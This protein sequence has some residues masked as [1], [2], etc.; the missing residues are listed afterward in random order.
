M[1]D[2]RFPYP[3]FRKGQQELAEEVERTAR[4]GELLV[5]NAPTGFGK[6]AA[7]L[8][9]LMKAGA[10]RV[11]YVVRTVNEVDPVIRELKL[12]GARYTF[13]FSARRTCPL[14][15]GDRGQGELTAEEFWEN[16][17][18]ARLRGLCQYYRN[19]QDT[20][21]EAVW[22]YIKS[23]YSMH[24]VRIAR[25]LARA[26][27]VCPFLA[28]TGL[29]EESMFTVAVYP[30]LFRRD[31]FESV[32]EPL[33]Y[34]D[35]V[36]VVDE[37]HSLLNA[38][39]ILEQRLTLKAVRESI[40]DLK[41]HAPEAKE[42]ARVLSDLAAYMQSL[43][44]RDITEIPK[45]AVSW[46]LDSWDIVA[47]AAEEVRRRKF[48]QA[49]ASGAGFASVR[50]PLYRVAKWLEAARS[51]E[52]HI[53]AEPGE[54]PRLLATPVDPAVTAREP[55]EKA[56]AVI[57]MSGTMPPSGF[58]EEVLGVKR[59]RT[60][61]DTEIRHGPMVPPSNIYTVV[62]ADITTRYRERSTAMYRRIAEYIDIIARALPG[63]KLV[64]YPSYDIMRRV[65]ER[66]PADLTLV[67]EG[68][69][70]SLEEARLRIEDEWDV[71]VS[72][73]A[74]GKLVE[75]V[76]FT[77]YEGENLLHI[78]V[79]VGVPYP[80]P[81][82]YTRRHMEALAERI[83]R[84]KARY[85]VYK[86]N[87]SIKVRQALGRAI[88]GPSDRAVYVLLD[89]RYLSR[90]LRELVRIPYRR[91]VWSPDELAGLAG[92]LREHLEQPGY[93]SSSSSVS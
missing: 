45:D 57:L 33:D 78:V 64:V 54:E 52:Y 1:G 46:A 51:D 68:Q 69:A 72:A 30:Y 82:D 5:V 80:Q 39:T 67:L 84:S 14:L 44:P 17:R 59:A 29:V 87:A 7:V 38:H 20:P 75:G 66:L 88:R 28:L 18:L 79:V 47:D 71:M 55:L 13:L 53:F 21:L 86:V 83:G 42:V 23:H 61:I 9:G 36:V 15:R 89:K 12:L 93:S 25:D 62:A 70:T 43:K 91:V 63:P 19:L 10:E 8:Y 24:A 3:E 11:L 90:D 2:V 58:V 92:K 48:E 56:R 40:E 41:K 73:V 22:E 4:E 60:T 77:N 34:E 49:L 37:A 35:L 50:T 26:L 76:E 16:C 32:M 6:T 27:Q 85:Y 74:G 81:D 31:I 65:V